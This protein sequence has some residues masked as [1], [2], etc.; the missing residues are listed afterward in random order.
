MVDAM[1]SCSLKHA[2]APSGCAVEQASPSEVTERD[3]LAERVADAASQRQT[4]LE[5][6]EGIVDSS[7]RE[8]EPA[9]HDPHHRTTER[10]VELVGEAERS[11][12]VLLRGIDVGRCLRGL[13]DRE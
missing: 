13:R 10:I 5:L 7:A 11:S 8:P 12:E 4:L 6:H 3:R 2:R 1:S 9:P